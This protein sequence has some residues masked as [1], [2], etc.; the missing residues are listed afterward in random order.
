MDDVIKIISDNDKLRDMP[1]LMVIEVI[2]ELKEDG[3]L[4]IPCEHV[5]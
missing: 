3:L 4:N 1:L 5:H 2:L